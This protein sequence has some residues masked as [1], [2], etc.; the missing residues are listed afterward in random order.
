MRVGG[1]QNGDKSDWTP[2]ESTSLVWAY[3][4]VISLPGTALR[5]LQAVLQ[6]LWI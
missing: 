3:P 6:K 2:R 1:I 5:Y 4:V